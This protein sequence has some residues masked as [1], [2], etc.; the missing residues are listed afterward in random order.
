MV[1]YRFECTNADALVSI[2]T[3]RA[4]DDLEA[5]RRALDERTTV[6]CALW[7]GQRLIAE[8]QHGL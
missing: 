6:S 7:R 3:I 4:T 8:M 5:M 2:K 1:D